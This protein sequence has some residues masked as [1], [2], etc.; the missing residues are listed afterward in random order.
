MHE[1]ENMEAGK[2]SRRKLADS[3]ILRSS[4]T[5]DG[6]V[7]APGIKLDPTGSNRIKVKTGRFFSGRA[8]EEREL[9]QINAN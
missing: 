9:S 7:R 3:S 2:V 5:E 4:A 1:N 6:A 8:V